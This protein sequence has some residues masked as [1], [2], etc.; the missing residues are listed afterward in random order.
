MLGLQQAIGNAAT[1]RLLAVARTPQAQPKPSSEIV[2]L[3]ETA[4]DELDDRR[5]KKVLISTILAAS[6]RSE[7][8][9]FAR[10]LKAAKHDTFGDHFIFLLTEMEEDF[11]SSST[12]S[13]MELFADAGVDITKDLNYSLEPLAAVAKFKSFAKE[14]R[15]L[16]KSGELST[17]DA[18]A[19]GKLISDAEEELRWIVGRHKR[20]GVQVR[21]AAGVAVAADVL[22]GTAAAL[23]ADDV[24]VIG[25]ADDVAIPFVII[26]AAVL[27]AAAIFSGG[28]KP[29]IL[30][31]GPARAK[32]DAVLRQMTDLLNISKAMAVQGP[33]AAGQLGNVAVH[34]ARLLALAAVGGRPS[35][36][37]PKRNNDD[38][39]HWWSE[40]KASLKNFFQ[41]TKGASRKQIMRE[42]LKYYSEE[43]IAEIEA[44]LANAET[45]MGEQVGRI[46]PPP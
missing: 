37:P 1:V 16:V 46:L 31:Y 36:E 22:W 7:L 43:Q 29:Q 23:A 45:Q 32:V 28:S 8:P 3:A 38:D 44:A 5:S 14:F 12:V 40:I 27:S 25:I 34:L 6:R 18:Q 17:A 21:Q 24:T 9:A 26:G 41:A 2:R 15:A 13:I 10:I 20:P 33:R 30:D 35:G 42:L 19:L 39:K 4:I 11:G